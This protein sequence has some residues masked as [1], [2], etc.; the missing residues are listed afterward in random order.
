MEQ[1]EKEMIEKIRRQMEEVEIPK[2]L[3]PDAIEETLM[4]QQKKDR[5]KKYRYVLAAVACLGVFGIAYMQVNKEKISRGNPTNSAV[6]EKT[7]PESTTAS[8]EKERSG[9]QMAESYEEIYQ[10]VKESTYYGEEI[11][12]EAEEKTSS[13]EAAQ[14]SARP[15]NDYSK[16]NTREENVEEGD[17]VKTD[18]RYIYIVKE[19]G[20]EIGIVDT[21]GGLEQIA[22]IT[23]EENIF[24]SEIYVQDSYLIVLGTES[25]ENYYEKCGSWFE[26]IDDCVGIENAT[27]RSIVYDISDKENPKILGEN[28]QSGNYNTSR[29]HNGYLYVFSQHNIYNPEE[30]KKEQYIPCVNGTLLASDKICIPNVESANAY[31]VVTAIELKNPDGEKASVGI[32]S[33]GGLTY[34][35]EEHIYICDNVWKE[36][37]SATAIRKLTYGN[38]EINGVAETEV[39]GYLNDSFSIDEYKGYLR[40]AVTI[41]AAVSNAVYV[42]DEELHMT[43][44]IEGLAEGERIYSARFMGNAGYFVTFRETDPLFSVD[45]SNPSEPKIIGQLK[46][47]GFSEYLHPYGDGL[48]LGIGAEVDEKGIA[49]NQVKLSMFDIS[50]SADVKE[51]DKVVLEDCDYSP[52]FDEYKSVLADAEKNL[53]GFYALGRKELYSVYRYDRENGF[54]CQMQ[55]SVNGNFASI[56]GIYIGERFYVIA[57]NQIEAYQIG[58]YEKIDDIVL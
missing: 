56:R 6:N 10:L 28:C 23:L 8:G 1:H 4:R 42:L 29:V 12:L 55:E 5:R 47:P 34:V 22:E 58:T 33:N 17:I 19:E 36:S 20:N 31:T 43:G 27:T 18:G 38:G 53:I 25:E 50:N 48:L 13:G 39:K 57:G 15:E 32:L 16:T 2:R 30:G 49:R 52:A 40:M 46:I 24:V 3:R 35:S 11:T 45:L 9:L 26:T 54:I 7:K 41:D 44:K 14:D 51:V 21:D 37:E